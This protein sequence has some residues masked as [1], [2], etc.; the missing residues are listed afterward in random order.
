MRTVAAVLCL[1]L[2]GI[3]AISMASF[4]MALITDST[5]GVVH[6]YDLDTGA[7]LGSF[8]NGDL[9]GTQAIAIDQS[10]QWAFV[11]TGTTAGGI[12]IYNY[13]TG[14]L[15]ASSDQ[16]AGTSPDMAFNGIYGL[17]AGQTGN[18]MTRLPDVPFPGGVAN[19]V[20]PSP[21]TGVGIDSSGNVFG[22]AAS[23][24]VIYRWAP[25]GGAVTGSALL[26]GGG[27]GIAVKGDRILQVGND[28]TVRNIN[29]A[30]FGT[31]TGFTPSTVFTQGIDVDFGHAGTAWA[32]GISGGTPRLQRYRLNSGGLG[33]FYDAFGLPRSLSQVTTATGL[34]IV[35]A[36][37]P[38]TMFAL[39]A[40]LGVLAKRRRN[41][42]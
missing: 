16:V 1:S 2:V 25:L 40:G 22:Y 37:E 15:I 42:K 12:G 35:V 4:E 39:A 41:K 11:G 24:N 8:G 10:R 29:A 30:N 14:E 28:L 7:Y 13:N 31:S 5:K 18:S 26:S 27:S 3:P 9:V 32:L 33:P 19:Y 6:R 17:L 21:I 36:P 34:A 20:A 23:T 38:G